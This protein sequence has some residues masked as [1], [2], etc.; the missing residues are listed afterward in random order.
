[1]KS[2]CMQALGP[3]S[4]DYRASELSEA[5]PLDYLCPDCPFVVS[6][7]YLFL[8]KKRLFSILTYS[9]AAISCSE[10]GFVGDIYLLT[11]VV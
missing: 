2:G 5:C 1:M 3:T 6:L 11:S 4:K 8:N 7:T 10:E 9:L